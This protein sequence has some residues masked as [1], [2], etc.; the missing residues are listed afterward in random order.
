MLSLHR[1]AC[2]LSRFLNANAHKPTKLR[3]LQKQRNTRSSTWS[4]K[5]DIM[6]LRLVI[7]I[8]IK[9]KASCGKFT[10]SEA[11]ATKSIARCHIRVEHANAILKSFRILGFIASFLCCYADKLC[12][13]CAA[14]VNLQFPLFMD[15]CIMI[16]NL[17]S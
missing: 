10:E 13:P 4:A 7:S 1:L 16:L 12:Q 5:M 3:P 17:I 2:Y 9:F 6:P 11:R 14:L 15:G 8:G